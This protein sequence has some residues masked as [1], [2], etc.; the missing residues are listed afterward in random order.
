MRYAA[1]V[2]AATILAGCEPSCGDPS[3]QVYKRVDSIESCRDTKCVVRFDDGTV[4][5]VGTPVRVGS[6]KF[7]MLCKK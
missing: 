7:A 2:L 5:S 6:T 4:E 3:R 1:L